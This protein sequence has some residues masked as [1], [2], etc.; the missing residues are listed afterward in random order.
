M[1]NAAI[2]LAA[3]RG[4]RIQSLTSDKALIPLAGRPA[5]TYSV[6][7]YLQSGQISRM[8]IIYRDPAQQA[9]LHHALAAAHLSPPNILWIRGGEERQDSVLAGL[10]ALPQETQLV[11]IHDAARPLLTP[12]NVRALASEA[13]KSGAACLAHRVT[14]TIKEIPPSSDPSG[15]TTPVQ[16][17]DRSRLWA[18]ETP[19]VFQHSLI[20]AAYEE[21]KRSGRSITDD[22][23]ALETSN[24]PITLLQSPTPNPKLTHPADAAWIEYLLQL[25][26]EA[27]Q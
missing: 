24:H 7:A 25:R 9:A 1:P 6:Q 19:Q 11:F 8:A 22:T 2:I 12:E 17:I 27:L 23:S 13:Q 16:T 21:V 3:G 26:T 15:H 4:Q 10:R 18:V 14:D 5:I 20:L